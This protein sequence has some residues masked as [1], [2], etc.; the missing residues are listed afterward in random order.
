MIPSGT[1]AVAVEQRRAKAVRTVKSVAEAPMVISTEEV[2]YIASLA[3]LEFS[4]AEEMELARQMSS[5]LRYMQMLNELDTEGVE[6]M[7]HVS[8]L[9][10]VV[11]NDIVK[12]GIGVE[13]ALRNAPDT[14]GDYFRVPKVIG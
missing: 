9:H 14:L 4:P 5:I 7:T 1:F 12:P 3:R 11:R 6:P 8:D 13:E 10:G 2:R